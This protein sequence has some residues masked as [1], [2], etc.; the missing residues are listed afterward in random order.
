VAV[1]VQATGN[2]ENFFCTVA[3]NYS[4]KP[5]TP[6]EQQCF[7]MHWVDFTYPTPQRAAQPRVE[8]EAIARG[9]ANLVVETEMTNSVGAV[10]WQ[11]FAIGPQD[12]PTTMQLPPDGRGVNDVVKVRLRVVDVEWWSLL[13]CNPSVT[14]AGSLPLLES[15]CFASQAEFKFRPGNASVRVLLETRRGPAAL[16]TARFHRASDDGFVEAIA[17][18][19]REN[20]LAPT[21]FLL[22]A[23]GSGVPGIDRIEVHVGVHWMDLLQCVPSLPPVR[24]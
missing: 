11:G 12:T 2:P 10:G 21:T 14:T 20:G 6:E 1:T 16:L 8:V 9:T 5:L 22:P 17:L 23:D 19:G 7:A 3:I 4:P 15:Q 24:T 13:Q 18:F